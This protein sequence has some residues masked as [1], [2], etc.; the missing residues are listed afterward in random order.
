[1]RMDLSVNDIIK[2]HDDG[3]EMYGGIYGIRSKD[4]I[5]SVISNIYATF[6]GQELYPSAVD[7]ASFLSYG[8]I[9]GHAF[10]DGNKRVGV[11]TMLIFLKMN[12]YELSVTNEEL[13]DFGLKVATSKYD[14]RSI[15]NWITKHKAN[16]L[17][18][19]KDSELENSM[20]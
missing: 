6:G 16:S 19:S 14:Q 15:A 11:S 8:L 12:G 5:D 10:L 18:N 4:E 17:L 3:I 20:Q 2:I 9:K 1:M 7:K 13:I